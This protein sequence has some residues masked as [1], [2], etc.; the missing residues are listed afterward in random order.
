MAA[1][2]A[3]GTV[4]KPPKLVPVDQCT[5]TTTC[6]PDLEAFIY[7][8]DGLIAVNPHLYGEKDGVVTPAERVDVYMDGKHSFYQVCMNPDSE[9]FPTPECEV[10][11]QERANRVLTDFIPYDVTGDRKISFKDDLF[12]DGIISIEDTQKA[13]L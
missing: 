6:I 11:R 4:S 9:F 2:V 3:G 5:A 7:Q 8:Y 10:I 1:F 13:R 12:P